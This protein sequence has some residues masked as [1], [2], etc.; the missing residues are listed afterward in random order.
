MEPNKEFCNKFG[1]KLIDSAFGNLCA[2]NYGKLSEVGPDLE[3]IPRNEFSAL[4]ILYDY[5]LESYEKKI[6]DSILEE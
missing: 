1:G 2:I 3:H 4:V 6:I 5:D